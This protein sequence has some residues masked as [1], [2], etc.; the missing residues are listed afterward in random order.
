MKLSIQHVNYIRRVQKSFRSYS[1]I[2]NALSVAEKRS[3]PADGMIECNLTEMKGGCCGSSHADVCCF[4]RSCRSVQGPRRNL[5]SFTGLWLLEPSKGQCGGLTREVNWIWSEVKFNSVEGEQCW[6]GQSAG[7]ACTWWHHV[8]YTKF[9]LSFFKELVL[10][11]SF[12][13]M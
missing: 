9:F 11:D 1:W 13:L 8:I 5:S 4:V 10:S 12:Y 7:L 2:M 6:I 3:F